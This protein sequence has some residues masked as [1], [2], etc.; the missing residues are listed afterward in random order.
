MFRWQCGWRKKGMMV[1]R[2]YLLLLVCDL[3][4]AVEVYILEYT[5]IFD[6]IQ[7][8]SSKCVGRCMPQITSLFLDGQNFKW[9]DGTT[10]SDHKWKVA[11][12]VDQNCAVILKCQDHCTGENL[13]QTVECSSAAQS[14][15]F[16]AESPMS[17]KTGRFRCCFMYLPLRS[18]LIH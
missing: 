17:T 7:R 2:L 16:C 11:P 8:L 12:T 4:P 13:T 3:R 14:A 6:S 1:R 9:L 5:R 18:F 10:V 15:F